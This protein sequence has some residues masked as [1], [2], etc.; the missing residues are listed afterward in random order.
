MVWVCRK[1]PTSGAL[2]VETS[3]AGIL[4]KIE[5]EAQFG[6]RTT[7]DNYPTIIPAFTPDSFN[8]S[9]VQLSGILSLWE[10]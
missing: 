5:Y 6:E 9:N 2:L 3:S 1:K 7:V 4:L 10:I 8:Y